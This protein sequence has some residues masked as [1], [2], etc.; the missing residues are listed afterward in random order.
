MKCVQVLKVLSI[1]IKR[2]PEREQ[3]MDPISIWD[4]GHSMV[5]ILM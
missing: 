3:K 1:K 2:I 4:F 5:S